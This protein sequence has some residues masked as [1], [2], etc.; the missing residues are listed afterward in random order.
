MN[1][2]KTTWRREEETRRVTRWEG[3]RG[4]NETM[5]E[6]ETGTGRNEGGNKCLRQGKDRKEQ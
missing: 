3:K 4:G 2:G 5:R 6:E 1:K